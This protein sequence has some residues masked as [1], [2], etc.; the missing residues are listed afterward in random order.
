MK[1]LIQAFAVVAALLFH[2]Q[3]FAAT[4]LVDAAWVKAHAGTPGIVFLDARGDRNLYDEGHIP[5]AVLTDYGRDGWRVTRDGVPGMLPEPAD[6]EKLIGGLGIGNDNHVVITAQGRDAT[7]MGVA[8][9]IYWT[10]K[11]AGHDDVSIL[12][13]GMRAYL[14]DKSNPAETKAATPPPRPFK[15]TLRPE[16]LAT[17]DDV[18]KALADKNAALIDH[19]PPQQFAGVSRSPVAAR[20]GTIPGAANASAIVMTEPGGGVFK[21][22]DALTELYAKAGVKTDGDAI[23][24]CNTGHWASIG[25]FVS[26]ELLGNKKARMY[27]GSVADWS[28]DPGNP[29]R[30]GVASK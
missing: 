15:V 1:K 21:S 22:A 8:T 12:D 3:A 6:L 26:H 13:G 19:R 23:N 17:A 29:M 24:F 18:R 14:A 11:V 20:S 2:G 16:L 7:E 30:P 25:W 4:P 28:R 27:D 10:F 5:G 9:R